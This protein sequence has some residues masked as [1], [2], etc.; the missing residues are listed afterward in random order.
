MEIGGII[1]L[2][3][4]MNHNTYIGVVDVS[5]DDFYVLREPC[6]VIHDSGN[7]VSF[8]KRTTINKICC[9]EEK[10]KEDDLF[11]LWKEINKSYSKNRESFEE[12]VFKEMEKIKRSR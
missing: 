3:W 10:I 12:L 5:I 1:K 6:I 9:E 11:L 7:I 2:K 4:L 8:H